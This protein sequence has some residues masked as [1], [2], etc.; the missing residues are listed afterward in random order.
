MLW[1]MREESAWLSDV[2][3]LDKLSRRVEPDVG[4]LGS[5]LATSQ[6]FGHLE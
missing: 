2:D 5:E 4:S 6:C 3:S 1:G